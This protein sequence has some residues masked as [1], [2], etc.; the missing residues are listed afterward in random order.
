MPVPGF[1]P[2][3]NALSNIRIGPKLLALVVIAVA[4][5]AGLTGLNM[6]TSSHNMHGLE[7][8]NTASNNVAKIGQ[9]I[10]QPLGRLR[11][12]TL[13]LVL[14]PDAETRSRI[15]E[16]IPAQV[17]MLDGAFDA[18][19]ERVPDAMRDHYE[20]TRE[21]WQAYKKLIAHTREQIDK[22]YREAA[23][24]NEVEKARA[25]FETLNTH[26][27]DAMRR[28][29][30]RS[31]ELYQSTIANAEN[32][33]AMTLTIGA[34]AA[35]LL[36]LV[37]FVIARSIGRPVTALTDSMTRLADGD[38][39]TE[40][41]GTDRRDELGGMARAV[42]VFKDNT[43]EMQRL[44][45]EKEEA[46]RRA[47][48]ERKQARQDLANRF[49]QSVKRAFEELTQAAQSMQDNARTMTQV[50]ATV[51]EKTDS[52]SR[53]TETAAE[54]VKTVASSVS[55]M[56]SSIQEISSQIQQST[57]MTR[58]AVDESERANERIETLNQS[59]QSIGEV[60]TLIQDI[61]ERTNLLAL[62]ATIEAARAGEAGKGFAV[63]ADEVK[64]LANQTQK[65]TEQISQQIQAIQS[66]TRQGVEAI[67]SIGETVRKVNEIASAIASSV[68]EQASASSEIARN[69]EA[70]SNGAEQTRQD[71]EALE[72][73]AGEGE[74]TGQQVAD[75]A[76]RVAAQADTVQQEIDNFLGQIRA[77]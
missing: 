20:A 7:R 68:E 66:E 17:K 57:E 35:V 71:V 5:M 70:A 46:D 16:K 73:S 77:T 40:V 18:W 58:S 43:L 23:F 25:Q 22:G 41:P 44:S 2:V 63:V 59:A 24:L 3:Q 69:I 67:R 34:G 4:G 12:L 13:S 26:V 74:R 14:A 52:V 48:E 45:R 29:N 49:E 8:V 36:A 33:R 19:G 54:N 53:N 15:A 60:V 62:N 76:D 42:Q 47:S 39:E 27:A 56:E 50:T 64:S 21:H 32:M 28:T 61:A 31:A 9:T 72:S 6:A 51:R 11:A 30:E 75:S 1:R 10:A 65:A 38:T 55:Q 37:G